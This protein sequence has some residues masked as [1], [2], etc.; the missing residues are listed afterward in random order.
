MKDEK[1]YS[2][3]QQ[4]LQKFVNE[5]ENENIDESNILEYI[6]KTIRFIESVDMAVGEFRISA[7]ELDEKIDNESSS[8]EYKIQHNQAY[9]SK[10]ARVADMSLESRKNKLRVISAQDSVIDINYILLQKVRNFL[11]NRKYKKLDEQLVEMYNKLTSRLVEAM[12]EMKRHTDEWYEAR[13]KIFKELTEEKM[14][15]V[16]EELIKIKRYVE[17]KDERLK[18]ELEEFREKLINNNILKGNEELKKMLD[19][20]IEGKK[21]ERESK[22]VVKEK[23]KVKEEKLKE[24]KE[25][26]KTKEKREELKVEVEEQPETQENKE[27]EKIEEEV[28]IKKQEEKKVDLLDDRVLKSKYRLGERQIK[29][30]K[31]IKTGKVKNL[32]EL[33]KEMGDNFLRVTRRTLN[34]LKYT[35]LIDDEIK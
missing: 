18:R 28:K 7:D 20:I 6:N 14:R 25:E 24:E 5:V 23:E 2:V 19:R 11:V 12:N 34:T 10:L 29:M 26:L 17:E 31:L 33:Q 8:D 22:E 1:R 3:V 32:Y 16:E 35:K 27:I 15:R 9:D 21:E 13:N 30:Y 4:E